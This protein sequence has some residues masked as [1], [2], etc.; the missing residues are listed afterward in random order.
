MGFWKHKGQPAKAETTKKQPAN[1]NAYHPS[2]SVEGHQTRY[3]SV[4]RS[5]SG[6][7]LAGCS[8][9]KT[10]WEWECVRLHITLD[11]VTQ[12]RAQLTSSAWVF[13]GPIPQSLF[14]HAF[15]WFEKQ[16]ELLQDVVTYLDRIF[17]TNYKNTTNKGRRRNTDR[18]II[19]V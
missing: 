2:T 11:S 3:K 10:V 18:T 13:S 8:R 7:L 12:I 9:V 14:T 4:A 19:F 5:S 6:N 17:G 16:I 1:G 15:T